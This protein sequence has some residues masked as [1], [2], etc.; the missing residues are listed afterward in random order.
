MTFRARPPAADTTCRLV[1]PERVLVNASVLPS[2]D[3]AGYPSNAGFGEMLARFEPSASTTYTSG[4]LSGPD[5]KAM[6]LPS[7]DQTGSSWSNLLPATT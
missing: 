5:E 3:H 6:R 1:E 2:G 4:L 7:G